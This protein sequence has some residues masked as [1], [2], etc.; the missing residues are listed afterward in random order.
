MP[1]A[2]RQA[3]LTDAAASVANDITQ[4]TEQEATVDQQ[5]LQQQQMQQ[6]EAGAD[7]SQEQQQQQQQEQSLQQHQA[8]ETQSP[9]Q[10][11]EQG[12]ASQEQQQQQ[13]QQVGQAGAGIAAAG[14]TIEQAA[15]KTHEHAMAAM[16]GG[17][18]QWGGQFDNRCTSTCKQ[19]FSILFCRF[20]H[21]FTRL[22]FLFDFTEVLGFNLAFLWLVLSVR[23]DKNALHG[24]KDF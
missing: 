9:Q 13:Q 18:P 17:P 4:Q 19:L 1:S 16:M 6:L 10:R 3:E 12:T 23:S 15:D 8:A 21:E 20:F 14:L 7:Q 5:D 22:R 2:D 24:C 11:Q